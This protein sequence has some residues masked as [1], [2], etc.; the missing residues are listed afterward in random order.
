MNFCRAFSKG[1]G[2]KMTTHTNMLLP[3]S[4]AG[5][6]LPEL[7]SLL[8]SAQENGRDW[9]YG[10]KAYFDRNKYWRITKNAY[11]HPLHGTATPHRFEKLGIKIKGWEHH[12]SILL[13]PQSDTFFKMRGSSQS[14]WIGQTTQILRQYTDRKIDI[15]FKQAGN[16]TESTF[17]NRLKGIWAVVVHSSMAGAQAA[18]HGVPCFATDETS[19]SAKF[20]TTDLSKIEDPIKPDNREELAWILADNQWT[21]DEIRSGMAWHHIGDGHGVG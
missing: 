17:K 19:V 4:V 1:C 9:Y 3:G 10:D 12:G 7:N 14:E 6:W 13:C 18:I 11:M 21:L 5:F 20:G 8:K 15:H 16:Q 2:G